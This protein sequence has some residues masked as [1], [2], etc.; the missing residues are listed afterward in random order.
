MRKQR[1][2]RGRAIGRDEESVDWRRADYEK[3]IGNRCRDCWWAGTGKL[4]IE[5]CMGQWGVHGDEVRLTY[6][7]ERPVIL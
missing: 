1:L 3:R 7:D 4:R 5:I 6:L 2:E